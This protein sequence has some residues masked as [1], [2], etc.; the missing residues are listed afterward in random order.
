MSCATLQNVRRF[1]TRDTEALWQGIP[2]R[3]LDK[4][5]RRQAYRRLQLLLAAARLDDLRVPPGNQ[6][7]ALKGDRKGAYSVR[8]NVQYRLCFVWTDQGAAE[9]EFIDYH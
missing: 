5:V 2:V 9:I 6:L 8:V 7:E 3:R 4:N 1:K